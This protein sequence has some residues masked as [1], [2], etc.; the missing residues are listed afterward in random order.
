VSVAGTVSNLFFT[1]PE[2]EPIHDRYTNNG[3]TELSTL[4]CLC[5]KHHR[6]VHADG[7]SIQEIGGVLMFGNRNGE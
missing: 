1:I 4:L 2:D 7:W 3:P 6:A 5:R